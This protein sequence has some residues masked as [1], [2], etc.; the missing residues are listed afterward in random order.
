MNAFDQP[1]R[2][3]RFADDL[4][5]S[6]SKHPFKQRRIAIAGLPDMGEELVVTRAPEEAVGLLQ[7]SRW[8]VVLARDAAVGIGDSPRSNCTNRSTN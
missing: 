5:G 6:G 1:D 8:A 4:V 3:E 2:A 7:A